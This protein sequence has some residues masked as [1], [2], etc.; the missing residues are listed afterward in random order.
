MSVLAPPAG[1]IGNTYSHLSTQTSTTTGPGVENAF[2]S[3][4]TTSEG[5]VARIPTQPYASASFTKS[6]LGPKSMAQN[7]PLL[8]MLVFTARLLSWQVASSWLFITNEPSPSTFTTSR[9][10]WAAATPIAVG[11]P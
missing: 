4:G 11:R 5:L 6:G 7:R 8:M 1:T 10:G 9:S 2:S 3:A